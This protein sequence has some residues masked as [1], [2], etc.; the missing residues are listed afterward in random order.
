MIKKKYVKMRTA[1]GSTAR[2]ISGIN[3]NSV[4]NQNLAAGCCDEKHP[5]RVGNL[6][7]EKDDSLL[8]ELRTERREL[9]TGAQRPVVSGHMSSLEELQGGGQSQVP[10]GRAVNNDKQ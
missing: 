4:R 5:S 2:E 1:D 3:F 6:R 7:I 8:F 9:A 10:V